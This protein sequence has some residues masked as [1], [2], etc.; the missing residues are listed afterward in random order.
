MSLLINRII[1]KKTGLLLLVILFFLGCKKEKS[2]IGIDDPDRFPSNTYYTDTITVKSQV[3]LINDSI[4]TTNLEGGSG[5][6]TTSLLMAGAYT[7]PIFGKIAAEAFT[8]LRLQTEFIELPAATA[9]SGFLYLSYSYYY[10]NISQAQTLDVYKLDEYVSSDVTYFSKS[11]GLS[12]TTKIGTATFNA[13]SD[14]ASQLIVRITDIPYLQSILD[15]SKNNSGFESEIRG[16]AIV[17]TNNTDGAIIRID[18]NSS[19]TALHVHYTQYGESKIYGLTL[20]SSARKYFR[21]TTDRSGTDLA[22]LVNNYDSISTDALP[23]NSHRSYIQALTGIRT[24]LSFPYL[25]KL[26]ETFPN[27]AVI[28][29][30]LQLYISSGTDNYTPNYSLTLFRTENG[31]IRRTSSGAVQYVQPDDVV[32]TSNGA[33]IVVG[34]T[35]NSYTFPVRSFVQAILLEQIAHEPIIVSPSTLSSEINRLAFNDHDNTSQPIKLKLYFT[36]TK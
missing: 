21:I 16:L 18:G 3:V 2:T 31:K 11:A 28:K 6:S 36:T 23:S 32:Q 26:R 34:L 7:D 35:S 13:S 4:T 1:F 9:D 15:A 12:Y 10:G 24:R 14:S 25:K 29:G 27:I 5:S 20:N 19:N 17:P 8:R 22:S 33:A 30:E